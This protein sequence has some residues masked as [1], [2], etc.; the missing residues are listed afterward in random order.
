MEQEVQRQALSIEASPA[1]PYGCCG[2]FDVCSDEDVLSLA[3]A[4]D[5]FLDWLGFRPSTVCEIRKNFI[6]WQ[7]PEQ[8]AGDCTE[9]YLADPC[10]DPNSYE[11]GVCD[12]FI[13][14]FGR[15]RRAGPTREVNKPQT[16][17]ENE[18]RWRLDGTRVSSEREWDGLMAAEIILQDIRRYT[19]TGNAA[20]LGLYDGLENLVINNYTNSQGRRCAMMDSLVFDWNNNFMAGGAGITWNGGAI[21]PTVDFI[22]VLLATYRRIRRRISWAPRLNQALNMGDMVLVLPTFMAD[23]LLDF[24][25]CWS[26]CPGAQYNETNLNSYEARRFRDSLNGGMFGAGQIALDGFSIPLI[27]YDWE[28]A[29]G[30]NHGDIYLLTGQAANQKLL[31]YEYLD[32]R[33]AA[34]QFA[35]MS[36]YDAI[37][38]GRFLRWIESDETCYTQRVEIKPRMISWA[39]WTNARFQDVNCSPVLDVLSPDACEESF[40]PEDSYSIATCP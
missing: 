10:A 40:F 33:V 13:E 38:T 7:R 25:T 26:V 17:C 12:F 20:T 35:D 4:G 9:G 2:L 31:Y 8:A 23:C 39:P 5:R 34:R 6:T 27:A 29:K 11:Y 22:D 16:L 24:F 3:L 30:P 1:T 15:V 19:V 28:L 14:D 21:A 36:K 32:Q 37:E 18:P